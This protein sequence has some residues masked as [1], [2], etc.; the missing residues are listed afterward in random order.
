MRA[1]HLLLFSAL[2][3]CAGGL[4][5]LNLDN[6]VKEERAAEESPRTPYSSLRHPETEYKKWF[7]FHS[8]LVTE[9]STYESSNPGQ[10]KLA[11]IGDSITESWR[12]TSTGYPLN[13]TKGTKEVFGETLA[14]RWPQ[15]MVLAIS[16]DWTQHVLWRLSHGELS[17]AMA[18]DPRLMFSLLIGTNNLGKKDHYRHSANESYEGIMAVARR[19]L[20]KAKGKLLLNA[21]LPRGDGTPDL[22][23]SCP[24]PSCDVDP[25]GLPLNSF[26]EKIDFVNKKLASSAQALAQEFPGRVGFIDCGGTFR[27]DPKDS[28]EQNEVRVDLM[29][30]R[31]HPNAEGHQLMAKCLQGALEKLEAQ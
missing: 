4:K 16:G 6:P 1:T 9:A 23:Q 19:L 7:E 10:Y 28:S 14:K 11:L 17:P 2:C 3:I 26:N 24:G 30:D 20:E 22:R 13:R 21:L 12:G 18:E 25:N 27:T 5:V 15:P 29:P 31:L 8:K